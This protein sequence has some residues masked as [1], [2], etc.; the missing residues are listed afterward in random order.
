MTLDAPSTRSRDV[1]RRPVPAGP[2]GSPPSSPLRTRAIPVVFM[3]VSLAL[4]LPLASTGVAGGFVSMGITLLLILLFAFDLRVV[5]TGV[6]IVAMALAP[7]NDI[8]PVPALSFV[9]ASDAAFLVGFG[10]LAPILIRH[11]FRPPPMF[12]VGAGSIFVVGAI[13]SGLAD[14]P[15]LSLNHMIRLIVGAFGLPVLMMI[16]RPDRPTVV[17]LA[18]AYAL[19][20]VISVIAALVNGDVRGTDGRYVGLTTHANIFGLCCLLALA[21]C[22][23]LLTTVRD[24]KRWIP[25]VVAVISAYGIWISGSRAALVVAVAV[26][27]VYPLL[28]RSIPAALAVFGLGIGAVAFV[29]RQIEAG[30]EN[31]ALGRLLGSSSAEGSDQERA[32]AFRAALDVFTDRPILGNGFANALEAHNVY[33]QIAA[34]VG[35]IGLVA[36]L[37][38]IWSVVSPVFTAPRPAN[39]LALPA[40]AYAMIAAITSLMWDRFIWSALSLAFLAVWLD[41]HDDEDDSAAPQIEE[42]RN[43]SFSNGHRA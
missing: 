5:G 41:R 4:L 14:E 12:L 6:V 25:I 42:P 2:V 23:F 3:L 33:L 29:N 40:A 32:E 38:V 7:L 27:I 34:A 20:N 17:K 9:T 19:G 11:E 24:N 30:V 8:R 43:A 36:Y 21:I 1:A 37:A 22:P 39:L 15:L 18:W 28:A 13:A 26:A 35:T 16:W 31:N 10:I